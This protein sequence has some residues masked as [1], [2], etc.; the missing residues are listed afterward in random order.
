MASEMEIVAQS[1]AN[2]RAH[3]SATS[4]ERRLFDAVA[5]AISRPVPA[6]VV[7]KGLE[8]AVEQIGEVVY[9]RHERGWICWPLMA[10]DEIKTKLRSILSAFTST[11]PPHRHKKRGTE[12]VLIGIGKMQ[13]ER[14][15]AMQAVEDIGFL[16]PVDMREVA[17]YRDTKDDSL[18]ARPR[19]EFEDGR[20]ESLAHQ[21]SEPTP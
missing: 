9:R 5:N 18:W 3:Y 7:V 19:E 15:R 21:T 2:W 16:T 1:F 10:G 4:D 11:L 20:F 17:I 13:A 12:Y 8:H 6:P 14:W